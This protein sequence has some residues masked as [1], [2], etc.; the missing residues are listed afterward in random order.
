MEE[1]E[2]IRQQA[3]EVCIE[4]GAI[5]E[6]EYH[7]GIYFSGDE[8]VQEAYKVANAKI[9]KGQ[10]GLPKRMSRRDFTDLIKGAYDENA[11]SYCCNICEEH[12]L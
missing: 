8:E 6:C 5:D 7:E 2:A 1:Q 11:A 12:G 4:A 3:L 9:T 10:I